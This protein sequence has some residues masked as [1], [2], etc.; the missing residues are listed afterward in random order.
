[1]TDA[2]STASSSPAKCTRASPSSNSTSTLPDPRRTFTLQTA[3]AR[4]EPRRCT[5]HQLS[6][7]TTRRM[8]PGEPE[9]IKRRTR[10][11]VN[12]QEG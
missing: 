2:S 5:R 8:A 9:M 1:M 6:E 7:A 3:E 10:W 11:T 4:E 12:G